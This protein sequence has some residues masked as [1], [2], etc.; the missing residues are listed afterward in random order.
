M[1]S[2][3][4]HDIDHT[5]RTR[6]WLDD[7]TAASVAESLRRGYAPIYGG[8]DRVEGMSVGH[9][10]GLARAVAIL[11]AL[12]EVEFE[13]CLDVGS[14]PGRLAHLIEQVFGARCAG[15]DLG[16]EFA[17][18]A[19]CDFGVPVYV[20]NAAALPFADGAFDLVLC[21]EVIEHVEYPLA[22]LAELWRVARRAVVLTTQEFC[23]RAWQRRLHMATVE[24]HA[25]HAERNYFAPADFQLLFGAG[26]EV[27]AL[28]SLPER[29]RLFPRA[30]HAEL[31]ACLQALTA[32]RGLGPGSFGALVIARKKG[33]A[34][35]PR[36]APAVALEAVLETDRRVDAIA[37]R[38]GADPLAPPQPLRPVP[39][40][41][42]PRPVCPECGGA[43]AER[44]AALTCAGCAAWFPAGD[45]VPQLLASA[46]TVARRGEAWAARPE[47][48]PVRR[49]LGQPPLPSAAV[50]RALRWLLKAG[51]FAVRPLPMRDKLRLAWLVLRE[52]STAP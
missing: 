16:R 19:R 14:G 35:P 38:R 26:T 42:E 49:A 20:A 51:D 39:V 48:A 15:V 12:G 18:A 13:T 40:L 44:E 11:G 31:G 7:H 47:L 37:A 34:V 45:G 17:V 24:R 23:P 52:G 5:E 36:L 28:L 33:R 41:A 43:L 8:A 10:M 1:I 4:S 6:A 50:R 25:P 27:R 3:P 22:V 30:S 46:P 9:L 21:S 29:I 2:P 32:E